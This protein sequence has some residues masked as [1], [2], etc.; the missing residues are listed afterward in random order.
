MQM[1]QYKEN[2]GLLHAVSLESHLKCTCLNTNNANVNE[3]MALGIFYNALSTVV[4]V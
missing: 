1:L 2:C 4:F 3:K